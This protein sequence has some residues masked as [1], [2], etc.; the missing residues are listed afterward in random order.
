MG[1]NASAL[2]RNRSVI[3]SKAVRGFRCRLGPVR[4]RHPAAVWQPRSVRHLLKT[5]IMRLAN[6]MPW[7]SSGRASALQIAGT[8]ASWR[9]GWHVKT[10]SSADGGPS[11]P[12]RHVA[13]IP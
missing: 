4:S 13:F 7:K 2:K 6:I 5:G 11:P 1:P 10:S 8:Q 3:I 12:T 9:M